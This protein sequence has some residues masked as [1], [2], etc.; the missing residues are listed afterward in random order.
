MLES[1]LSCYYFIPKLPTLCA[2]IRA[3]CVTC[4]QNNASQG[5]RPNPGVQTVGTLPFEDLEVDFTEVKPYRGYK[6]LLVVVCTYSGWAK[7]NPTHTERAREVAKALLRDIIPRYGLPLSLGFDSGPPFVSEII[8]TLS[9]TLGIKWKLHT[10]YRPQSSG[11]V[12]CMNWTLK[13]TLAKLCQETQ[14]SWVDMY[15]FSLL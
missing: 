11:K 13:T 2:Q 10:A 3:R 8:Q 6:Y 5:P 12:E 4:V 14:L 15:P 9:K 1:I 7:A